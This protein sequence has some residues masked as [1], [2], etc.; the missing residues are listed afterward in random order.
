MVRSVS[1]ARRRG[2]TLIELL[3]VIAIIAILIGL[4]LPAVQKI[5]EAASRMQCIN[6]MHQ[7]G[8]ALH[9]Y[10]DTHGS[11]FPQGVK[12]TSPTNYWSWMGQLLPYVE[13]QNLYN[14]ADTWARSGP[15]NY[16][17]W[18]WGDFW[19]SPESSPPNPALGQ[20]VKSW[21][22]PSDP[23]PLVNQ[24]TGDWPYLSGGTPVAFT[25]YLGVSSGTSAD[26][27]TNQPTGTFFM[28]SAYG[29]GHGGPAIGLLDLK[30][31]TSNT[32]IVGERPPSVDLEYGWWFAGAGWDGSGTGDVVLGA[33]EYQ[34]AAALGCPASKVG[35]QQGAIQNPCDQVHFWSLHTGGSNFLFGDGSAHFVKY[36]GNSILPAMCTRA[37]GE[38]VDATQF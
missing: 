34:Y 6:N 13:Q 18:P 38:E 12:Y 10:H 26:F 22:C 21:R 17:W 20:V 32:A 31:G 14:K 15:G 36:Q 29:G 35:L 8:L 33:L 7:I 4:L 19:I 11:Q 3:V 23:R 24:D 25:D 5:R 9:N 1:R 27:T 16:P 2:F 28:S 37:G 30:D